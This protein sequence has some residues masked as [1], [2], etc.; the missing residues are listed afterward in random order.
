[1]GLGP[2][3]LV[4]ETTSDRLAWL[5]RAVGCLLTATTQV[6]DVVLCTDVRRMARSTFQ[7]LEMSAYCMQRDV[8]VYGALRPSA[9]A[10]SRR[11]PSSTPTCASHPNSCLALVGR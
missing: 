2:R 9:Q 11:M 3:Q 7:V 8:A 6:G 1:M 5:E 10:I 4:E